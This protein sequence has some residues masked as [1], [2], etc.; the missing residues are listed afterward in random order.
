MG[1]AHYAV[2][3][4][5]RLL[6]GF[7]CAVQTQWQKKKV[8]KSDNTGNGFTLTRFVDNCRVCSYQTG[9]KTVILQI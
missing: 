9:A 5:F 4:A 6:M 2:G 1:S 7:K 8:L 3:K